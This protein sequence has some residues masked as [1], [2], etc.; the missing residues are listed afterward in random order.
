MLVSPTKKKKAQ[1]S[2]DEKDRNADDRCP[3]R[4]KNSSHVAN[5]KQILGIHSNKLWP[6][7]DGARKRC[8]RYHNERVKPPWRISAKN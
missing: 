5:L 2:T 7:P 8:R 1:E 3:E 6:K 4:N